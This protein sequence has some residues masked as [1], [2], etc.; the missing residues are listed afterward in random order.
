[1]ILLRFAHQ[2]AVSAVAFLSGFELECAVKG[3]R[4]AWDHEFFLGAK[5]GRK[6]EKARHGAADST[7]CDAPR[8]SDHFCCYPTTRTLPPPPPYLTPYQLYGSHVS[9]GPKW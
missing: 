2:T 9:L 4:R 6:D 3:E 5:K 1:M 8:V 7:L